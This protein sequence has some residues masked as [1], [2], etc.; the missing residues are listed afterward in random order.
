MM[1]LPVFRAAALALSMVAVAAAA[2]P[3]RRADRRPAAAAATAWPPRLKSPGCA[4]KG[5]AAAGQVQARN[6]T[7]LAAQEDWARHPRASCALHRE[8][9]DSR[10]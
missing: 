1:S 4:A 8:R 7:Q 2:T 6:A 10:A 9:Q 5:A 3:P